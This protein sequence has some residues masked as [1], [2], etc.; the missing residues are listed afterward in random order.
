MV[1]VLV[2]AFLDP[3]TSVARSVFCLYAEKQN[4]HNNNTTL[5]SLA[6][7]PSCLALRAVLVNFINLYGLD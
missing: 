3:D 5:N 7:L 4:R 2:A 6:K 1:E